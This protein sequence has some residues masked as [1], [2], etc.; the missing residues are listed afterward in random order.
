MRQ[1]RGTKTNARRVRN[2]RLAGLG[3]LDLY[4]SSRSAA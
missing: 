4:G 1:K 3:G 2:Y